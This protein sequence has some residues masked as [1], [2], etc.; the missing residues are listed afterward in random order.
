MGLLI[1]LSLY[2]GA[3]LCGSTACALVL[4]VWS[5]VIKFA[6]NMCVVAAVTH[7]VQDMLMM[8]LS[9][10]KGT[11]LH[12]SIRGGMLVQSLLAVLMSWGKPSRATIHTSFICWHITPP[13]KKQQ[14]QTNKKP[15]NL[16]LQNSPQPHN[17]HKMAILHFTNKDSPECVSYV[18][19]AD[20]R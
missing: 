2:L 9:P 11:S 1:F 6:R 10:C 18:H 5:S 17:F 15:P 8:S 7:L 14:T 19:Q 12:C 3:T 20:G 16:K 4:E 13:Q